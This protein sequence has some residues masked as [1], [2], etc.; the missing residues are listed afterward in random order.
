MNV[1]AATLASLLSAHRLFAYMHIDAIRI[2]L[3]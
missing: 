3:K 2:I 1:S